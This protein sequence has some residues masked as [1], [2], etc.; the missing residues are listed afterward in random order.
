MSSGD[1]LMASARRSDVCSHVVY[2]G[3]ATAG[4]LAIS[5]NVTGSGDAIV[6]YLTI[7]RRPDFTSTKYIVA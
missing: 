1:K 4:Q 3:A 5:Y 7:V 6:S 2:N